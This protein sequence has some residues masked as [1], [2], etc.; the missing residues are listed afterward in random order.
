VRL[1]AYRQGDQ[2]GRFFDSRLGDSLLWAILKITEIAQN[3]ATF[4]QKKLCANFGQNCVWLLL[5]R[6]SHTIIR[7]LGDV[8]FWRIFLKIT[9]VG[10]PHFWLH[11]STVK[12]F[13]L[14]NFDK[15]WAG[16]HFGRF[17]SQNLVGLPTSK[18]YRHC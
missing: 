14:C 4:S 12:V 6:F 10:S 18:T 15:K 11:F 9:D 5:G 13:A 1:T 8:Y 7:P 3:W 16:P 17:F 2:I